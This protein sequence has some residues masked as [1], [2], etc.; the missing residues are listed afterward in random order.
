MRTRR[1]SI[2][3][4]ALVAVLL[5]A[6]TLPA[7]ASAAESFVDKQVQMNIL[8]L[9]GYINTQAES[10]GFV[11]PAQTDVKK[12]GALVAPVW[13]GNPWTGGT[14]AP[15]T[16]KG[17]YTYTVKA[18]LSAF[19]LVG[20]LS[21][22]SYK[23]TGGVPKWLKDER[24]ASTKAGLALV[25]QYVELWA[26]AHA[27]ALPDVAD[28]AGGGPVGLQPGLPIWPQSPWTHVAMTQGPAT[29]DFAYAL[30]EAGNGYT[31]R[32]RLATGKDWVLP[33]STP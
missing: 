23:V 9:Q 26:R 12:G 15:G 13:P 19:T 21:K 27:G 25:Q 17:T 32:A 11:Y 10:N 24:D 16:S 5:L 28:V 29:G 7:A 20:H 30:T 1:F 6:A 31:L 4:L 33:G 18:D 22:G 2:L 8:L 3:L 14:M